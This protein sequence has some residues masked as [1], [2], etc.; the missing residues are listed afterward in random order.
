MGIV[1]MDSVNVDLLILTRLEQKLR[2]LTRPS[3]PG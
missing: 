1:G 2:N 3:V